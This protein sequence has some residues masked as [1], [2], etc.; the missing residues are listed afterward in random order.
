MF[1]CYVCMILKLKIKIFLYDFESFLQ[2]NLSQLDHIM[3]GV[4]LLGCRDGRRIKKR[5]EMAKR[6]NGKRDIVKNFWCY[7]CTGT[8][9]SR[10]HQWNTY[11]STIIIFINCYLMSATYIS[12]KWKSFFFSFNAWPFANMNAFYIGTSQILITKPPWINT[13]WKECIN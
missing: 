1:L 10:V 8:A 4:H 9:W 7:Q 13:T 11:D 12:Q 2:I 6:R 3:K 5:E